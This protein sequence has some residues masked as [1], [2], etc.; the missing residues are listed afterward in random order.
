MAKEKERGA[1]P[2]EPR[3]AERGACSATQ[4]FAPSV[5]SLSLRQGG[6]QRCYLTKLRV[7]ALKKREYITA[8][9]RAKCLRVFLT[10]KR[11]IFAVL[12]LQAAPC[13]ATAEHLKRL[14]VLR[15]AERVKGEA[16]T[17]FFGY[18]FDARQKSNTRQGRRSVAAKYTDRSK[19]E[20]CD[21][22]SIL[23]KGIL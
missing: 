5:A 1:S 6:A 14:A 22:G 12:Y 10:R 21:A 9:L 16:L 17:R 23:R 13:G 18:F 3:A 2:F 11:E 20:L 8:A 4:Q 7:F 19:F 15:E